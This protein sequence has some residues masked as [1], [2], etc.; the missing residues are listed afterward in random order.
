MVAA[1]SAD[2]TVTIWDAAAKVLRKIPT[3]T[4]PLT[5]AFTLDAQ[6]VFIGRADGSIQQVK[7]AESKDK[8]DDSKTFVPHHKGAIVGLAVNPKG[9]LLF[10]ASADKTIQSWTLPACT[11]KAKFDHVGPI[12][13]MTLSKDGTHIAAVGAKVVKVW[14]V[15]DGKEVATLKLP[16][17]AK[18][19]SLSPDNKRVII[20][21]ADT[22][23]R[24]YELDGKL[25][26]TLP[27]DGP[28]NAVAYVDAK[29][30]VTGG[31]GQARTALDFVADL[32]C[33]ASRPRSSGDVH[34]QG[35]PNRFGQRRQDDQTLERGR[36]QGSQIADQRQPDRTSEPERRCDEN[37]DGG[38]NKNVKVWTL[39]D[40]KTVATVAIPAAAKS[41]AFSPNGQRFAVALPDGTIQVHDVALGKDVQVF[42]DHTAAVNSLRFLADGRT[43]VTA[44]VDKTARVLDVGVLSALAA[45][46]AG[47]TFAQYH[48]NGTQ[49]VTAGADK[50]VKL[51]DL[52]KASVLKSFGPV[53]DPIK[54]V[55][56]SKD[57]T[58]I[59]VAA[60]KTAKAWNIA[61]GK[62]VV[63][64]NHAADV[65]SLSFSQDGTRIAT[66]AADK[67]T[68]LWDAATGKELQFFAQDDAVDAVILTP[69]NNLVIS[70]A[71]KTTRTRDRVDPAAN[72]GGRGPG[73]RLADGAD[74]HACADRRRRQDRQALE[75]RQ[76]AHGTRSSSGRRASLR[77]VAHFQKRPA[78]GGGGADQTVRVYQFADAKE[79]GSVK[80]AGECARSVS[81]RTISP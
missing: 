27:H 51:W 7:T 71:G 28:V 61:D 48:G 19:L 70:A 29:H 20:A 65:L 52:A 57:F 25:L 73:P 80:V 24:V 17:D 58:K 8:K 15:A 55:T 74:Q 12:A 47:P 31:S 35:G 50:T 18:G 78:G 1:A 32:A 6:S 37:R 13:A 64:L 36:R 68:R 59:G 39:A 72:S 42:T 11:P 60:G 46:P 30:V 53:A 4:A 3:A 43:L 49:L 33:I 40:G 77:S 9:D 21:G 23:A 45:H 81:R 26:E 67:Q 16:A 56:F 5:V 41:L 2:K 66:G 10:S 79:L 62:D 14:R 44:S 54:A 76:R 34:A 38:A 75:P 69:A 63:T 22:L